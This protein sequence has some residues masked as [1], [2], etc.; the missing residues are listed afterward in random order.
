MKQGKLAAGQAGADDVAFWTRPERKPLPR[1]PKPYRAQTTAERDADELFGGFP[2][3][4]IADA[5]GVDLTTARRWR[6]GATP[7]PPIARRLAQVMLHGDLGA[8]HAGWKDW[9]LKRDGMLVGPDGWAFRAG[10][11]LSLPLLQ[12]CNRG[13]EQT[14]ER[15][16]RVEIQADWVSGQYVEP[17]PAAQECACDD[18]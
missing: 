3:D 17:R 14:I 15:L 1:P 9:Y 10:E 2:T 4:V 18:D 12:Q 6:R 8:I 13:L 7:I 11:I 16:R 5:M